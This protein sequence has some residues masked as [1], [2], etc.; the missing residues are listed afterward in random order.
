MPRASKQSAYRSSRL[1]HAPPPLPVT[2]SK[3][4]CQE[5]GSSPTL[6]GGAP[7]SNP[8]RPRHSLHQIFL[9]RCM[10]DTRQ[11]IKVAAKQCL[12]ELTIIADG[13]TYPADVRRSD[14]RPSDYLRRKG[15]LCRI[16]DVATISQSGNR[17]TAGNV[18]ARDHHV[19]IFYKSNI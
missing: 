4:H 7:P 9:K 15:G 3:P 12:R 18:I 19:G 17:R 11:L 16:G 1:C 6:T 14:T 8:A 2:V 5:T 13:Y 10:H